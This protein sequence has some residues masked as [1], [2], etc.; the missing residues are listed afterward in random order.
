MRGIPRGVGVWQVA[1]RGKKKHSSGQTA[2]AREQGTGDGMGEAARGGGGDIKKASPG[3]C[4]EDRCSNG[5]VPESVPCASG[6]RHLLSAL[7]LLGKEPSFGTHKPSA[8]DL[9]G[10]RER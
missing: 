6:C 9:T 1:S 10:D 5:A 4:G 2:L 8:S 3:G 7:V